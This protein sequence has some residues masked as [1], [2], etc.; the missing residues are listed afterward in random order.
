MANLREAYAVAARRSLK[1]S[2][3]HERAIDR[4]AA[5]G[6]CPSVGCALWRAR[7]ALDTL[8]YQSARKALVKH[9][10]IRYPSELNE[11]TQRVVEQALHEHLSPSC[12]TCYGAGELIN[13]TRRVACPEC[14]GHRVRRYSDQERSRMMQLSFERVRRLNHKIT[15]LLGEMGN[16]ERMVNSILNDELE[17][18]AFLKK[19]E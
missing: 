3:D 11:I 13:E 16:W 14:F 6:R 4:I 18:F 1:W 10:A 8:S 9:Y 2:E 17:R 5:A 19:S 15:W 12:E 7:Y